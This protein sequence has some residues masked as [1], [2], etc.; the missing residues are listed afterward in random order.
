MS[1]IVIINIIGIVQGMFLGLFLASSKKR[2]TWGNLF[3]LVILVGFIL[4][5]WDYIF[6]ETHYALQYPHL[7]LFSFPFRVAYGP[8]VWLLVSASFPR[9]RIKTRY[10]WHFLL[11]GLYV[12]FGLSEYHLHSFAYKVNYLKILFTPLKT[13]APGQ[14]SI[15]VVVFNLLLFGQFIYYI[16]RAHRQ[17]KR[18]SKQI[19]AIR[20][21]WLFHVLIAATLLWLIG[22]GKL[23]V[24]VSYAML[25]TEMIY[26]SCIV[27]GVYLYG[28]TFVGLQ[29]PEIFT[30]APIKY[31]N[32]Q[33]PP[34]Q[35][36]QL[37]AQL[38]QF[39]QQQKPFTDANL[40]LPKLARQIGISERQLSQVINTELQQNFYEFLNTYRIDAAKQMLA[41]PV[42]ADYTILAIAYEVG[43]NSKSSFNTA[44]K[45]LTQQTPSQF[46]K[47][48]SI[49]S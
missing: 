6:I 18:A 2:H 15:G 21:R 12:L 38:Q 11:F 35:S 25:S 33:L 22:I 36:V 7:V 8:L 47:N 31:Q 30:I 44:F 46:R 16:I 23:L 24:M 40:T 1:F 9:F 28:L 32:T 42:F 4:T 17:I 19:P 3:L 29:R 39:M 34:N 26:A 45:K 49:A 20:K 37:L 48:A 13:A 43:F 41:D 27:V 10:L 14:I 5:L